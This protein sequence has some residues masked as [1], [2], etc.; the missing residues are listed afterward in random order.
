ME[1]DKERRVPHASTRQRVCREV[2]IS[3]WPPRIYSKH[4]S[5]S[6]EN[7]IIATTQRQ[8]ENPAYIR[9]T[10]YRHQLESVFQPYKSKDENESLNEKKSKG[11]RRE[12]SRLR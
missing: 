2:R 1:E 10:H 8:Y 11:S 4:S 12:N 7:K 3:A 5:K 9:Y 6:Y